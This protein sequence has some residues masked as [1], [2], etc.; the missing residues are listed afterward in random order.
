MLS[1]ITVEE[2]NKYTKKRTV[3]SSNMAVLKIYPYHKG[4]FFKIRG[5]K[6]GLFISDVKSCVYHSALALLEK[7]HPFKNR[8]YF[9]GDSQV[10]YIYKGL[11]V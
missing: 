5:L 2:L 11:K 10:E 8:C 1:M 6:D 7:G 9:T 3:V 4:Q